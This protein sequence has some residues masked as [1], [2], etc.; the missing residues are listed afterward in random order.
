M[1]PPPF[2]RPW[3]LA[4]LL[5]VAAC[6]A[7]RPIG[8]DTVS[9]RAAPDANGNGAVAVDVVL[10]TRLGAGDQ[11]AKLAATEW[12]RRKQQ[13]IRD[14][15]DGLSVMSWELVPGQSISAPVHRSALDAYVFASYASPGD[16]RTRLA[17]EGDEAKIML[18][19]TDFVV[20]GLKKVD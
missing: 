1:A 9:I 2:P 3:A 17:V 8:L 18:Q 6:A 12:F 16:H 10:V 19:A 20:E 14:N 7:A 4:L 5:L 13:L 11:V 15:P